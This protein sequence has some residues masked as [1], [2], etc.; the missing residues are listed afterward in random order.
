MPILNV[1]IIYES[2][3]PDGFK[4]TKYHIRKTFEFNKLPEMECSIK[5]HDDAV[6]YLEFRDVVFDSRN[7]EYSITNYTTENVGRYYGNRGKA[8]HLMGPILGRYKKHGW[9]WRRIIR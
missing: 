4:S 5:L 7:G 6:R 8:D 9:S 2:Q 1:K 3:E